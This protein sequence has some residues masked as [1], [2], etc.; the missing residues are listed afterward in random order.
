MRY[1]QDKDE[2]EAIE[3]MNRAAKVAAKALCL[4]A[5]C[6]VIIVKDGEIIGEGYNAPPDDDITSRMCS[7]EFNIPSNNKH[8][9]TCCVHAEWRAIMDAVKDNKEKIKNSKLYFTRID[10]K[11]NIKLSGKPY[12]TVCSRLAQD[13]GIREFILWHGEG[14]CAYPADEYNKLSYQFFND[15]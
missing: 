15:K 2:K 12:C 8:D 14:I 11:G 1:L 5:K 4:R 13:A 7:V 9:L 3:W 6:G 10:E